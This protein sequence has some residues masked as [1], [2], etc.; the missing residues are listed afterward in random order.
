MTV[1]FLI[2]L[3]THHIKLHAY[4]DSEAKSSH[5][6][7]IGAM[8]QRRMQTLSASGWNL[9]MPLSSIESYLYHLILTSTVNYD[10][11]P[12]GVTPAFV[13]NCIR[14][15]ARERQTV[16]LD[17]RL[18]GV[19][20]AL[21]SVLFKLSCL[22]EEI[23]LGRVSRT[24]TARALTASRA[25]DEVTKVSPATFV[26]LDLLYTYARRALCAVLV[27][28]IQ[29]RYG[30]QWQG[31]LDDLVAVDWDA[32]EL[33]EKL[34]LVCSAR[35]PR[36]VA[37]WPLFVVGATCKVAELRLKVTEGLKRMIEGRLYSARG[38]LDMIELS[39]T[40]QLGE[41]ILLSSR[42][43]TALIF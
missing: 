36:H 33:R 32:A 37:T 5:L 30:N 4:T 19:P 11:V 13:D 3:L 14:L 28:T 29:S 16:V 2:I 35:G 6:S 24:T 15:I 18:L 21:L 39:R 42:L 10:V 22:R 7:G 17:L 43:K 20:A 9:P 38:A 34:E 40:T 8:L 25:L 12:S 41:D 31:D 26:A 1:K 23:K 27:R